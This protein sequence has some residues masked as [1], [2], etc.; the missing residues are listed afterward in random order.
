MSDT[1]SM[2]FNTPNLVFSNRDFPIIH[3]DICYHMLDL[4]KEQIAKLSKEDVKFLRA[5][6][7]HGATPQSLISEMDVND[8]PRLD[9]PLKGATGAVWI[10]YPFTD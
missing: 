7:K 9:R 1:V 3:K 4:T 5:S 6:A 10:R 2:K 8:L